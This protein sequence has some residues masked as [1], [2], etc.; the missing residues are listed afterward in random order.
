MTV[1]RCSVCRVIVDVGTSAA[2]SCA[3]C[4]GALTPSESAV[5]STV[6]DDDEPT[7]RRTVDYA[8]EL[9]QRR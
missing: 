5:T 8:K 1:F 4:G 7:E 3:A 6:W 2:L 9:E